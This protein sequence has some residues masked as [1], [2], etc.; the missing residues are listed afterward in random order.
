MSESQYKKQKDS[1][2]LLDCRR[3]LL[4]LLVFLVVV[5]FLVSWIPQGKRYSPTALVV[6]IEN[7][8]EGELTNRIECFGPIMNSD[9]K[10]VWPAMRK[11]SGLYEIDGQKYMGIDFSLVGEESG[12]DKAAIISIRAGQENIN[13]PFINIIL[14]TKYNIEL[15]FEESV[16]SQLKNIDTNTPIE[17]PYVMKPGVYKLQWSGGKG[18]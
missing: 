14:E 16:G 7:R 13:I 11:T 17:P 8:I 15:R 5:I 6:T 3:K 12:E 10:D 1:K 18:S 4:V 2:K 9:F